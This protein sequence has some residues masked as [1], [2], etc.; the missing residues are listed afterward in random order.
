MGKT[1]LSNLR[2]THIE[3][4]GLDEM[5]MALLWA[6]SNSMDGVLVFRYGELLFISLSIP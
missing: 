4:K 3:E 1:L 5:E 2:G 6:A